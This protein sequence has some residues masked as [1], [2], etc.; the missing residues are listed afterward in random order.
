MSKNTVFL[1]PL[2]TKNDNFTRKL[3]LKRNSEHVKTKRFHEKSQKQTTKQIRY[4]Q[5]QL[6]CAVTVLE[7]LKA[8][9]GMAVEAG[10]PV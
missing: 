4:C 3:P 1:N 7:S 9:A 10:D 5:V 8:A 2:F 6:Y